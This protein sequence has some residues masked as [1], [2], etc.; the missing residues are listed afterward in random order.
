MDYMMFDKDSPE[1]P[2][3]WYEYLLNHLTKEQFQKV[4]EYYYPITY[5]EALDQHTYAIAEESF[6]EHLKSGDKHCIENDACDFTITLIK[7]EVWIPQI[8]DYLKDETNPFLPETRGELIQTIIRTT[9][10][11]S[12]EDFLWKHLLKSL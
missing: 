2:P 5:Q 11:Y 8:I 6:S 7:N 1:W 4:I 10:A 9:N 3:F 12:R